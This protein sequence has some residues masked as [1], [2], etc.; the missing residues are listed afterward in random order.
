[1]ATRPPHQCTP[2]DGGQ[3]V[4]QQ[5]S[6]RNTGRSRNERLG[7]NYEDTEYDAVDRIQAETPHAKALAVHPV[8]Y[9]AAAE[10]IRPAWAD[11]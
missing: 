5:Q 1:M 10:Q 3:P 11:H 8:K 9:P 7:R 2:R 4:G 6:E